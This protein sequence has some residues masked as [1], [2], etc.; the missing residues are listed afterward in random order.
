MKPRILVISQED[1]FA[2]RGG[3]AIRTAAIIKALAS[4]SDVSLLLA[5]G[6]GERHLPRTLDGVAL[7]RVCTV[8]FDRRGWRHRASQILKVIAPRLDLRFTG[9]EDGI[10]RLSAGQEFD[11]VVVSYTFLA[12]AAR[13]LSRVAR[14]RVLDSHNV[15]WETRRQHA[16]RTRNPMRRALWEL[17]AAVLRRFELR[18][19]ASYD[20]VWACSIPDARWYSAQGADAIVVP[21][22]ARSIP[23]HVPPRRPGAPRVLFVGALGTLE[24]HRGATWLIDEV[25]P[26]LR[27][28]APGTELV[29]AG[30]APLPD[31]LARTCDGVRVIANPDELGSLYEWS[32]VV[33]V[34]LLE[35][36]GTRIKILEGFAHLRPVVSTRVGAEGLD[37]VSGQHALIVDGAE[38]FAV[39]LHRLAG[40]AAAGDSLVACAHRL[41]TERYSPDALRRIIASAWQRETRRC[42]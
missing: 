34:P 32:N 35:G 14:E 21:N 30:R 39:E 16:V 29:V 18:E 6:K 36:S 27:R 28:L 10:V 7:A 37:L 38:Q 41:L 20:A 24:N 11:L 42:A 26:R 12:H 5:D 3:S 2:Q 25:F 8:A 17:H 40:D 19:L 23:A 22:V 9:I 31:L 13:V 1:V 15:E 4:F 33:A